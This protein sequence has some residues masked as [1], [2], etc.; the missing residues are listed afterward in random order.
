MRRTAVLLAV[1]GLLAAGGGAAW[2]VSD[3]D[4]DYARQG[5]TGNA[6]NSDAPQRTEPGCYSTVLRL[7]DASGHSYLTVG[8]PQVADGETV[9][10]L[11]VCLDPGGGTRSCARFSPQG[12]TPLPDRPGTAAD[13]TSG[14]RV[15]F[16]ADDNLDLGEHDS[17]EQVDNGPSDGGGIQANVAPQTVGT[18]LAA[19]LGQ[20]R[21]FLLTHP[22]PLADAGAGACADGLCLSV[23]TQRR[24]VYSGQDK[25]DSRDAADYQGYQPDPATCSGPT[26][27]KADC[28][29]RRL[30]YYDQRNGTV[31]AEPGIQ[32]YEDPDPQGSPAGPA[33][34]IPAIY[35]G[36]CG[37]VVGGGDVAGQDVA[38][39]DSPFTND[40]GQLVVSTGC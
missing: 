5:C 38:A 1:T 16:G 20:D 8:I 17:S 13:P 36:T 9:D 19:V 27:S 28:G 31:Y 10:A 30:K 12:V 18:W 22:L 39:P 33:Y 37:L 11:V 14:L 25:K 26:D 15:Y 24:V 29:G 7:D 32:V 2:A 40:A 3:G 4:Y 23:Q 6:D 34:P 21:G 35:V